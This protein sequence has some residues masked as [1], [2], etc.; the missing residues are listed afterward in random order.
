MNSI[1]ILIL[2]MA[3]F[4]NAISG[5]LLVS[6]YKIKKRTGM[7]SLTDEDRKMFIIMQIISMAIMIKE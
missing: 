1:T 2:A 7:N 3:I 4:A 6:S 5:Y